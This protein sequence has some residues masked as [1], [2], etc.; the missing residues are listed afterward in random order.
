MGPQEAFTEATA[1]AKAFFARGGNRTE[2]AFAKRYGYDLLHTGGGVFV[3]AK[4]LDAQHVIGVTAE[5]T[6]LY[7][8]EPQEEATA[9]SLFQAA[10]DPWLVEDNGYV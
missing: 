10:E 1:Q 4:M 8:V 7:Q 6:C 2:E 5:I 3:A 9:E